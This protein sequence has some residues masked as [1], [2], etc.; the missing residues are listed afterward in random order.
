MLSQTVNKSL[1]VLSHFIWNIEINE[2][3][4]CS[5]DVT[6]TTSTVVIVLDGLRVDIWM[7]LLFEEFLV[8]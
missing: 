7:L 8:I 5:L 2:A 4:V 6:I 3:T 1:A